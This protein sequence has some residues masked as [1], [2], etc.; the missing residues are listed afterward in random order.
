MREKGVWCNMRWMLVAWIAMTMFLA[1]VPVS[2][3]PARDALERIRKKYDSL[4][5][6]ELQFSRKI[7]FG[8]AR[9]EQ[10]SKGTLLLKKKHMY[11]I[12]FDAQTIVTNGT[13]VWSYSRPNYQVLIDNFKM[14]EQVFSP[15]RILTGGPS[16][17][18]PILLGDEVLD[19]GRMLVLKLSPPDESTFIQSLK[20]WVD[21]TDWLIRQ[22]EVA[23][24]NGKVTLY[25]V[26]SIRV[27]TGL[28]DSR[29][30]FEIPGGVD[31]VDL[32]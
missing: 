11:R 12:E 28:E 16:D 1:V 4:R 15:E 19:K 22:A 24:I 29:F 14:N 26:E 23:E 20:L 5:D 7:T 6:A 13:T 27:N 25:T 9:L 17:F 31:V 21:Q 10:S 2:A 8:L 18:R 30:V 32:R 3:D